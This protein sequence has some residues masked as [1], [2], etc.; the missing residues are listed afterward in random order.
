MVINN[1][2]T[3]KKETIRNIMR[4]D[5]FDNKS[6][7]TKK[8]V[9]NM[10]GLVSGMVCV[11]ILSRSLYSGEGAY[12]FWAAIFGIICAFCLFAGMYGIDKKNYIKFPLNPPPPSRREFLKSFYLFVSFSNKKVK[13]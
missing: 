4:A 11:S 7:K 6:Y 10:S 12:K 5:G 1:K 13:F 3:F 2:T 8:A 9:L